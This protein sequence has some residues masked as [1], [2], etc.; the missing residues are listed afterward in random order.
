[1]TEKI[2]TE[3]VKTAGSLPWMGMLMNLVR[4]LQFNVR[5]ADGPHAM[6][7]VNLLQKEL[8]TGQPFHDL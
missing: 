6:V 2:S 8:D 5:P 7:P 4:G 1:M 3:S